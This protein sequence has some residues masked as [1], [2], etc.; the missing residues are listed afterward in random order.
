MLLPERGESS[1]FAGR[2]TKS[3]SPLVAQAR[4]R[5]AD[6]GACEGPRIRLLAPCCSPPLALAA[7]LCAVLTRPPSPPPAPLAS[8]TA[9]SYSAS[10]AANT[11][12]TGSSNSV[13]GCS[14]GETSPN[15]CEQSGS[16]TRDDDAQ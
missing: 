15:D 5:S 9:Y 3:D 11:S 6:E 1:G 16:V 7:A 14:C 13:L 2:D 10:G 8:P 4:R 12:S